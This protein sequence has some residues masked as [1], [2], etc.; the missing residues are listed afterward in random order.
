MRKRLLIGIGLLTVLIILF[1][2]AALAQGS[3]PT[4]DEVNAIAK[5][6]YCPVCEN[7]PLDV[8]PTV[9]CEQW[10]AT[11]REKLA[12]GWT[13]EQIKDYFV[14]QYGARVLATP[15]AR[16]LNWLFYLLPPLAFL[17]G[18]VILFQA[19]R[20]WSKPEEEVVF[21]EQEIVTDDDPYAAQLEEELRRRE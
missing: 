8:C 21:E 7:I 5:Q 18:A 16:D 4:D 20:S 19:I 14:A 1:T 2:P 11:I 13:E 12:E 15:P 9:A 3:E 10:R 17:G 6:L